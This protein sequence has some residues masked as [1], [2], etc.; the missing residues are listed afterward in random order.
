MDSRIGER[1]YFN[2]GPRPPCLWPED[3]ELLHRLWL[4]LSGKGLGAGLH[5]RDVVRVALRRLDAD[6]H[7]PRSGD[8]LQE[9]SGQVAETHEPVN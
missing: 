1:L 8:V 9:A 7:S 3:V 6:L 2:L 4:E 5:H